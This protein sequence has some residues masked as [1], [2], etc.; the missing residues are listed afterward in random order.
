IAMNRI[1][2]LYKDGVGVEADKVEAAK[3]SVLAKR[4][5][6]TDAVLDDFFRT[7][8]EP[9]QRGALDAANRFRAG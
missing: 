7:L 8:D 9:T 4:A 5:A 1:A 6:N 3:W 2:H